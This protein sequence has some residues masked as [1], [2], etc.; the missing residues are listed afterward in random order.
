[1]KN[2][3]KILLVSL[4]LCISVPGSS[5]V[6]QASRTQTAEHVPFDN[7]INGFTS[8]DTQAAIEEVNNKILDITSPGYVFT[9]SGTAKNTWLLIG[10]VPSNVTGINFGFFNGIL[11]SVTVANEN[12]NTFD[13]ELYEHDGTIFTLLATMSMVTTRADEFDATDFGVVNVTKG[14][15]LAVKISSGTSKNPIVTVQISGTLSP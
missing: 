14:K 4:A 8:T 15:E 5:A 10:I 6:F 3:L 9:K 12:S 1:M 13:V 2:Y 7:S 11:S